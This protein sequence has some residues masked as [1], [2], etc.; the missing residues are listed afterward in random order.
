[1]R[2]RLL[3][4]GEGTID[5][6]GGQQCTHG[7]F[8]SGIERAFDVLDYLQQGGRCRL[9]DVRIV[10]Y[11]MG[12]GSRSFPP[13]SMV[14]RGM[15]SVASSA[16]TSTGTASPPSTPRRHYRRRARRYSETA[17]LD[18]DTTSPSTSATSSSAS[19]NCSADSPRG[20]S[21]LHWPSRTSKW[22]L[23]KAASDSS[24]ACVPPPRK[25]LCQESRPNSVEFVESSVASI[26]NGGA[27]ASLGAVRQLFNLPPCHLLALEAPK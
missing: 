14:R 6:Q 17:S 18:G 15:K 25:R 11:L 22:A 5:S 12:R 21:R 10:D 2:P 1:G 4:A 27:M 20:G 23:T 26:N 24:P 7:A 9:R 8:L 3:F 16:S 19:S 13:H